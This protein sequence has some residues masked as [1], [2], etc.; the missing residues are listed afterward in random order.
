MERIAGSAASGH[1][2]VNP[3]DT[4]A[5]VYQKSRRFGSWARISG[6]AR[7]P[8]PI[9]T[10]KYKVLQAAPAMRCTLSKTEQSAR[11]GADFTT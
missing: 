9:Q 7:L 2:L 11:F 4:V 8:L 1:K 10:S 5:K 3:A 6:L